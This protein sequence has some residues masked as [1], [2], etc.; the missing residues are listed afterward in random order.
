MEKGEEKNKKGAVNHLVIPFAFSQLWQFIS[1]MFVSA[2][3]LCEH[4]F[5]GNKVLGNIGRR[6]TVH[7][8]I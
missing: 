6:E 8:I 3:F 5:F 2:L 1:Q 4:C 7:L